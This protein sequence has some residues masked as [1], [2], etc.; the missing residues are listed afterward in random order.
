MKNNNCGNFG[1]FQNNAAR[2]WEAESVK[3]KSKSNCNC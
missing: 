3:I 2:P 1:A